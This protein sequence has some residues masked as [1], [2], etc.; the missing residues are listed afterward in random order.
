MNDA[1]AQFGHGRLVRKSGETLDIG[2]STGGGSRRIIDSWEEP[3]WRQFVVHPQDLELMDWSLFSCR[4]RS[5][6]QPASAFY[7]ERA[8]RPRRAVKQR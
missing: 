2:G 3:D 6:V 1:V 4:P 8:R 7:N 5:A